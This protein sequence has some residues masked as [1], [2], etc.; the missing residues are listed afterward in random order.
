MPKI[1]N[2]LVNPQ[3]QFALLH[4]VPREYC[5]YVEGSRPFKNDDLTELAG[6]RAFGFQSRRQKREVASMVETVDGTGLKKSKKTACRPRK[7]VCKMANSF[8]VY[9]AELGPEERAR[10]VSEFKKAKRARNRN[11]GARH[12]RK[13]TLVFQ[14]NP[15]RG[16]RGGLTPTI[17]SH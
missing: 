14:S 6:N 13:Q 3:L 17:V 16:R 15:T 5:E 4:R 7:E 11:N 8:Q 9:W 1:Y 12:G 2:K 10:R